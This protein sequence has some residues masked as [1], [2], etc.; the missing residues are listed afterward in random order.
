LHFQTT[1]E[2]ARVLRERLTEPISEMGDAIVEALGDKK[3][4]EQIGAGMRA[5][6]EAAN[7]INTAFSALRES[8]LTLEIKLG[9]LEHSNLVYRKRSALNVGQCFQLSPFYTFIS[10]MRDIH[11]RHSQHVN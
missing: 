7:Q 11:K 9:H 5:L 2:D 3:Y 1:E 8:H 6:E 10:E 4:E